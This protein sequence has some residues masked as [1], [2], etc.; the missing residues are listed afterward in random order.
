MSERAKILYVGSPP[1]ADLS[2]M[3]ELYKTG[4]VEVAA[5]WHAARRLLREQCFDGILIPSVVAQ[6]NLNGILD[7]IRAMQQITQGVAVVDSQQNVLWSNEQV[8]KWAGCENAVG[9]NVYEALGGGE[10][11]SGMKCPCSKTAETNRS[12][13]C[14]FKTPTDQFFRLQTSRIDDPAIDDVEILVFI[15]DATNDQRYRQKLNAVHEAGV[16]LS[17]LS[18]EEVFQMDVQDRIELLKANILHYTQSILD[19]DN[20]EIRLL[21]QGSGELQPLLF[22]GIDQEAA[23]RSLVVG[24][25]A[26]GVTGY[27]A[28]TGESYLVTDVN[29]D[30]LFIQSFSGSQSSLTVPLKW[31]GVVIGTFN[32]ES[33]EVD[34]FSES[35]MHFLELFVRN[36][37]MAL[38]TLDLLVAQKTNAAQKSVEAIHREVAL[39]IDKILNDAVNVMELY[40][41]HEPEVAERLRRILRNARDIRQVIHKIGQDL[42]PAEAVPSGVTVQRHPLLA[43][44]RV[45]V[46][47]SDESVRNDAHSLLERYGCIVET[48]ETGGEAVY[49]VRN[50]VGSESYNAIISDIGLPDFS[51]YQLMLRLQE[52]LDTVPLILMTGFGYDPGH[53]IV[54]ARQAGLHANAV[55]YKPFRL[56]QLLDVMETVLKIHGGV[57]PA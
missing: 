48:A 2:V 31:Q 7:S 41:G 11:T 10:I 56:D 49:M 52:M 19:Y 38:N 43:G 6:P 40:I 36:I 23:E 18:P 33:P 34:A 30:P 21:D 20:V 4:V 8:N 12:A 45:L 5:D 39:P 32:V 50:T 16:E 46:V 55:L 54:K 25:Q 47:D 37:A 35:D 57:T 42:A 14:L 22:A 1:S 15:E 29:S 51:G 24:K 17:N 3:E 26:N 27:V 28:A 44:Q 9:L 53:S 13:R